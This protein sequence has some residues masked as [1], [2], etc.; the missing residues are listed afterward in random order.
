MKRII[1]TTDGKYVGEMIDE[2]KKTIIFSNGETFNV[3]KVFMI[4]EGVLS[5]SNS[6]Y[7]ITV[8]D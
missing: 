1:S 5:L 7:Q 8:G 3:E 4:S 6:N 2:T